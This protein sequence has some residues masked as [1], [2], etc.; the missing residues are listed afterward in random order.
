M[1]PDGRSYA[2]SLFTSDGSSSLSSLL[3]RPGRPWEWVTCSIAAA[4]CA[5][6]PFELP[7][8]DVAALNRTLLYGSSTRDRSG[9]HYVAG[10]SGGRPIVVRI[11]PT[12]SR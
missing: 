11:Q 10:I 12:V 8:R 4:A 5:A 1:H 7:D 6:A 3:R 2:P 9:G